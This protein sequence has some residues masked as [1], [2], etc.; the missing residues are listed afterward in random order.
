M[1]THDVRGTPSRLHLPTDLLDRYIT[2]GTQHHICQ[3][4]N[5]LNIE[6]GIFFFSRVY[7]YLY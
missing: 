4:K 6:E 1:L 7:D 5:V 3:H 2:H